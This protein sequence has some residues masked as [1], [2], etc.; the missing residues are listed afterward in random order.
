[1]DENKVKVV[2]LCFVKGNVY[3]LVGILVVQRKLPGKNLGREEDFFARDA[4]RLD[5]CCARALVV[6]S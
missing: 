3:L 4:S 2:E 6:V 5:S 1:M